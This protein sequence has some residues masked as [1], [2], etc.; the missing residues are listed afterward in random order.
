VTL[1]GAPA[2]LTYPLFFQEN[3]VAVLQET[4]QGHPVLSKRLEASQKPLLIL[5]QGALRRPDGERILDLCIQI[6]EKYGLIH[7]Q[8]YPQWCGFNILHMA[9]ARVGALDLGLVP[10]EEDVDVEAILT[11]CR[12]GEIRAL[13]LLGVDEVPLQGLEKTFVIYQGHH[14][15]AGASVADVIL[16]G[17]AYTEKPG[18]YVNS[19]GRVQEAYASC[20]PPGEAREDWQILTEL[21]AFLGV[22]KGPQT[23]QEVRRKL[24][25]K[26]PSLD[27]TQPFRTPSWQPYIPL[28]PRVPLSPA[29]FQETLENFYM[30]DVMSRHSPTMA[31]CS[32]AQQA[33]KQRDQESC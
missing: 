19:E 29:P 18:L 8:D 17:A 3:R 21:L 16:P 26:N 4:L 22:S 15:E 25:F 10:Q 2:D 1:L 23:L 14:G 12:Q 13:Y 20:T 24:S 32:Q 28:H 7:P 5:G 6:A 9:A 31:A 30:T 27:H 33:L 11:R